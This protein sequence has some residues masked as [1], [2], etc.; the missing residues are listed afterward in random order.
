MIRFLAVALAV[1]P[2]GCRGAAVRDPPI[3][4]RP[5]LAGSVRPEMGPPQPGQLAPELAL[6]D[7]EG[8]IVSLASMR[9]S[10]V[11]V[12][13]TATWCPFCDSEVEHL[14]ALADAM[15]ARGVKTV[16][17]DVEEEAGVWR[18]FSAKHLVPSI[19]A[20]HDASGKAAA[21]FAPPRA[22]PSFDDRAQVVLDATLVVDPAGILRLFL[23]PDSAHFDPTF[24]ALRAE[25]DGLLP[26]AVVA[27]RVAPQT[28][29]AGGHAELCVRLEIAP[30]YHL[31]SDRPSSPSYVATRVEVDEAPGIAVR[32][33]LYPW[34]A[35]LVLAD[36]TIATFAGGV[37]IRVPVDVADDASPGPWRLR[38]RIR[39]QACTASRCLFPVSRTFDTTVTI[40]AKR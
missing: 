12:H 22:Q 27:V 34:P 38:G 14:D 13:F 35:P 26:E 1:L 25:L 4:E 20:L 24:H 28:L 33:A 5:G 17:V 32:E 7:L 9:G 18:D 10:W 3:W 23:L 19:V 11:V 15:A 39:Y 36:R 37:D 6:P 29:A 16:I 31:M 8:R 21:R 2:A 30:G 40:A